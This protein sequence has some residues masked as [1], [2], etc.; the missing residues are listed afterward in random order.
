MK[1]FLRL[2]GA[3]VGGAGHICHLGFDLVRVQGS[4]PLQKW[5]C[6]R[7]QRFGPMS[8]STTPVPNNGLSCVKKE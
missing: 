3:E 4:G 7:P 8:R 5:Y 1:A 6:E 2:A